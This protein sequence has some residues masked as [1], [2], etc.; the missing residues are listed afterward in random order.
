[1]GNNN[2]FFWLKEGKVVRPPSIAQGFQSQQGA[3]LELN[4]LGTENENMD[5]ETWVLGKESVLAAIEAMKRGR[6][7]CVSDDVDR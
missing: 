4:H 2:P 1:M 7:V 6:F 5:E 3:Y